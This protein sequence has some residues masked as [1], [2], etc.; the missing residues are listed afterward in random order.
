MA[1]I[2]FDSS[3]SIIT[4]PRAL[5][6]YYEEQSRNDE[7]LGRLPVFERSLKK[8]RD[9][10]HTRLSDELRSNFHDLESAT[11]RNDQIGCYN[12]ILLSIEEMNRQW[13][14][15]LKQCWL[16]DDFATIQAQGKRGMQ[17]A[18]TAR[19]SWKKSGLSDEVFQSE[20]FPSIATAEF[21]SR[22]RHEL[23]AHLG[24]ARQLIT[25]FAVYSDEF[26][27]SIRHGICS[28]QV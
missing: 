26:R 21:V 9:T 1:A 5:K 7:T 13:C 6:S 25:A 2:A 19:E 17:E 3:N 24:V 14:S 28:G 23:K 27:S 10:F 11:N 22:K 4:L 8:M 12:E 15:F 18:T 16:F 20:S